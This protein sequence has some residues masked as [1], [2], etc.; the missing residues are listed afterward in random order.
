MAGFAHV[1]GTTPRK[2]A[3]TGIGLMPLS[4]FALLLLEQS[5]H[6]QIDLLDQLAPLAAAILVLELA[7]PVCTR[8]ALRWGGETR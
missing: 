4:A 1:S 5:R 6:L 8:L 3:L 2:G 7:G